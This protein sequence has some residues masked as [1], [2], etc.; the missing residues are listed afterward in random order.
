MPW[1]GLLCASVRKSRCHRAMS[2][3]PFLQIFRQVGASASALLAQPP[4]AMGARGHGAF[5]WHHMAL[6][7]ILE[8][9]GP[10]DLDQSLLRTSR[11]YSTDFS[12][13]GTVEH[14]VAFLDAA[15]RNQ[16]LPATSLELRS[17]CDKEPWCRAMLQHGLAAV[18]AG[19]AGQAGQADPLVQTDRA[20]SFCIFE[21]VLDVFASGV[22]AAR[23][24]LY[25]EKV[26]VVAAT[27]LATAARCSRHQRCCPL[28]GPP[29]DFAVGGS[30]CVDFS[31]AG[32]RR[33]EH[34][35]TMI[36]FLAWA[37][38]HRHW[39]TPVLILENVPQFPRWLVE[40]NFGDLY[41]IIELPITTESCGFSM[42]R[43]RRVYFVLLRV[44]CVEL[45]HDLEE[46]VRLV[47]A[48]LGTI[49]SE[50]SDFLL[51]DLSEV[52]EEM[53]E[54]TQTRRHLRG[55]E[56]DVGGMHPADVLTDRERNAL[57]V[58]QRRWSGLG[59]Q[60]C[61]LR[62]LVVHLGDNP[63]VML[64]WSGVDGKIPTIRR[65]SGLLWAV[66]HK[67][68]LTA[69]ELYATMGFPTYR[70]LAQAA[71]VALVS[72]RP[73]AG[74]LAQAR[75][76][77]GNAMHLACVG[78]VLFCTLACVRKD[79]SLSGSGRSGGSGLSG[80]D[81]HAGPTQPGPCL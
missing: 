75:Q 14:A 26:Q 33:Q 53:L 13:I 1:Q 2:V 46:L 81:A 24:A 31:L 19:L 12:G 34:G 28:W 48:K 73:P 20:D 5:H 64:V 29:P 61:P 58:Y 68:W 45:H 7:V 71:G 74:T 17:A 32:S 59:P 42:I 78:T 9:V 40:R 3:R 18:P 72:L 27:P 6:E 67:R 25:D 55:D 52:Q 11:S 23:D 35:P 62:D 57:W 37:R 16:K 80:Q 50:I 10:R 15:L 65:S 66:S 39:G 69:R 76:G 44:G 56:H 8:F 60:R 79:A 54:F 36:V 77:I 4:A 21:D 30:P 49:P 63:E 38:K 41:R 43:R 70:C 22:S 47:T 51:A